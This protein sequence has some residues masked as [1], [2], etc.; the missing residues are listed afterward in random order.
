MSNF[1]SRLQLIKTYFSKNFSKALATCALALAFPVEAIPDDLNQTR[2]VSPIL[3]EDSLPFTISIEEP[4]FTL[5]AGLHS[6][7]SAVYKNKWVILA[8]R[9]NGLHGFDINPF[10]KNRQNTVAYVIDIET[11][12]VYSRDLKSASSGLTQKQIDELSVTSPQSTMSGKTL[13]ICGGYGIDS[14]TGEFNTKDTVTAIDLPKFIDWVIRGKGTAASSLRQTSSSWMQVTGGT[15]YFTNP[16]LEGL[17]IFG[18][19]FIGTYTA[20]SNGI[21]TKQVRRFQIIDTGKKLYVQARDSESPNPNYRRRDLN[22]VPI[23]KGDKQEFLALSGVFTIAGGIWTVPVGISAEGETR[24]AD[25]KA[26]NTFKQGMNNYVSATAEL[27]SKSTRNMYV[28]QLGGLSYETYSSGTFTPDPEIPFTNQVTT[29]QMDDEGLFTQYLMNN[30]Y[31]VIL[32]TGSNYGN[33]LLFGAAAY[34]FY[35]DGVP[36]FSNQVIDLDQLKSPVVIGYIVG[37][38]M[39]TLPNTNYI[40]DSTASPYVFPL[41][42]IPRNQR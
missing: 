3:P 42:L 28:V 18:Q 13:Y 29:I 36:L 1:P 6:G 5:P 38:I 30:E 7:A 8:G 25:P 16:H 12:R 9:T 40:T 39:S 19:N 33:R 2:T 27:Y 17:L 35:A 14:A 4:F 31:P 37:G 34:F 10:P 15:M 26:P 20:E 32:S 24:M 23:I 11:Q 21:Y 41:M 22:V